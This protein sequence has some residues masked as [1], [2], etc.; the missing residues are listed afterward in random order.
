M[1]LFLSTYVN[2]VD[3]KG[4]VSIPAPFRSTLSAGLAAGVATEMVIFPSLKAHA[5]DAAP[6]SYLEKLSDALD[7]PNMPDDER[8]LIETTVYGQSA[9][10]T[11][12]PE[13]RV[14]LP[15]H[16]MGFAGITETVTFIGRRNT[17][18]LWDP[19]AFAAHEQA[20]REQARNNNISLSTVL[21]KAKGLAKGE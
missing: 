7:N 4:R 14:I 13:G 19:V 11:L 21:A 9:Q 5:L 8:E 3:K 18:Q 12:D 10:L 1:G 17:F 2:K 6:L 16:L 15:D 20:V